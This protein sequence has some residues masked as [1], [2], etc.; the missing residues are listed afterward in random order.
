[1]DGEPTDDGLT[2]AQLEIVHGLESWALKRIIDRA[3]FLFVQFQGVSAQ[4]RSAND[5]FESRQQP[6]VAEQKQLDE[7]WKSTK[8]AL[9]G[10]VQKLD[11][12]IESARKAKNEKALAPLQ[13]QKLEA[14]GNLEAA[15]TEYQRK[16]NELQEKLKKTKDAAS[17]VI[18]PL[19]TYKKTLDD[20]IGPLANYLFERARISSEE[21]KVYHDTRVTGITG[22]APNQK[23]PPD[24]KALTQSWARAVEQAK[25][26]G[27]YLESKAR[28]AAADEMLKEMMIAVEDDLDRLFVHPMTERLRNDL[29]EIPSLNVGVLQKTSLLATNRLVARVDPRASAQLGLGEETDILQS[30]LQLGEVFVAAKTGG[31]LGALNALNAEQREAPPEI[32]SLNTGSQFKVTPIFD[33]SGQAMR[34]KFD[35]VSGTQIQE[36]NGTTNPQLPR[37]ERHTVNTEV[38]ITNMEMREISRFESNSKLGIPTTY[39]GGVPIFKDIPYFRPW[40][41]L[42]GWFV[43]HSGHDA[44]SQQ[45]I[46]FGQTTIYPTIG[47]LLPLLASSASPEEK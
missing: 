25:K 34:F 20:E 45:S 1:M 11:K 38:Q 39:W 14:L 22:V 17:E 3:E 16:S 4:L 13:K 24:Q 21:V 12:Q 31:P 26:S 41:P 36:P 5:E 42:L 15:R 44:A 19:E 46:I 32:Y 28:V 7:T 23:T 43:R 18:Q 30:L 37:I 33:P 10:N 35:Y 40:V 27:S 29:V 6:I 9:G 2:P 47:D 8:N